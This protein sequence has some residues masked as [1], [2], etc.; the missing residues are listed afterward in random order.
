MVLLGLA[1]PHTFG[2]AWN[3]IDGGDFSYCIYLEAVGAISLILG[4][5]VVIFR[6]IL[7]ISRTIRAMLHSEDSYT[8]SVFGHRKTITKY[9]FVRYNRIFQERTVYMFGRTYAL[10]LVTIYML[11]AFA[12]E[13]ANNMELSDEKP[14]CILYQSSQLGATL[15]GSITFLLEVMLLIMLKS[16]KDNF[17]IALESKWN[18]VLTLTISILANCLFYVGIPNTYLIYIYNW[19]MILAILISESLMLHFPVFRYFTSYIRQTAENPLPFKSI[20]GILNNR[21]AFD[22]FLKFLAREFADEN[23]LFLKCVHDFSKSHNRTLEGAKA[24]ISKFTTSGSI[25]EIN[26]PMDLQLHCIREVESGNYDSAFDDAFL[27]IKDLLE[28]DAIPRFW[29]EMETSKSY[30]SMISNENEI[31]SQHNN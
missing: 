7:L 17:K 27:H 4:S 1:R 23:L 19:F 29:F 5:V 10:L 31:E 30:Q 14:F 22:N 26:L 6:S 11:S 15:L 21:I 3:S 20:I 12:V 13:P 8:L 9:I 28:L 2:K 18:I 25:Y 16:V 24:I